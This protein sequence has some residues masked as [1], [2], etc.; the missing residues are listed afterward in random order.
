L[1]REPGAHKPA[2]TALT[3]KVPSLAAVARDP[4]WNDSTHATSGKPGSV[5][6]DQ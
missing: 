1:G 3:L 6:A 5:L 4:S 2:R